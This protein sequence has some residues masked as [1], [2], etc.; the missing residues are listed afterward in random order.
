MALLQH[1]AS[2]YRRSRAGVAEPAFAG[3]TVL[4]VEDEALVAMDLEATA[5]L[6]GAREVFIAATLAQAQAIVAEHRI[7]FA[8]FDIS[9]PDGNSL[10]LAREMYEAGLPLIFHSAHADPEGLRRAFPTAAVCSKPCPSSDL[11][12]AIRWVKAG[13][14]EGLPIS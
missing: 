14:T 6:E 10:S 13:A 12:G 4:V 7:D 2:G 5:L 8:I 11:V 3:D 1:S 9:L